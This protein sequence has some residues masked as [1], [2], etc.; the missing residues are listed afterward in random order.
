LQKLLSV[1]DTAKNV[2]NATEKELSISGSGEKVAKDII[3]E[4]GIADYKSSK[5]SKKKVHTRKDESII[6]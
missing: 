3:E 4:L 2:W 1:F 6:I 5:D